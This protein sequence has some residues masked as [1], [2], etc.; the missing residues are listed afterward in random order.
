MLVPPNEMG[1]QN[2]TTCPYSSS[3][4]E[5]CFDRW[6]SVGSGS[7]VWKST[8]GSPTHNRHERTVRG[9]VVANAFTATIYE[10]RVKVVYGVLQ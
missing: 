4:D 7:T 9:F 2:F 5:G 3:W 1:M 6:A 10:A 8:S